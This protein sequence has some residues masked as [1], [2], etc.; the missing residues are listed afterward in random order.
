MPK[1]QQRDDKDGRILQVVEPAA[2]ALAQTI[3]VL[4]VGSFLISLN[5][6]TTMISVYAISKDVYL[7]WATSDTDFATEN[8][9]DE[10][11]PAGQRVLITVPVDD[12]GRMFTRVHLAGRE[13]G[14]TIVV[15]EK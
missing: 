7:H 4:E 9:F 10:I 13:A 12:D 14:A 11:I 2:V 1:P 6:D 5:A 15:V 8:N 3:K